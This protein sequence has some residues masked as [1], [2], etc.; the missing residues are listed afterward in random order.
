MTHIQNDNLT[1]MTPFQLLELAINFPI[2]FEPGT[3]W[4]YCNQ[5]Y[6]NIELKLNFKQ[7]LNI[8]YK[9]L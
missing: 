9:F 4:Q 8:V 2:S 1:N 5:N 7:K 3:Q 6:K